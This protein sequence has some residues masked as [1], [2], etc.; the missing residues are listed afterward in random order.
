MISAVD[1]EHYSREA[2]TQ[3]QRHQSCKL[4]L[5]EVE[6]CTSSGES[7]LLARHAAAFNTGRPCISVNEARCVCTPWHMLG[8]IW[9]RQFPAH[10]QVSGT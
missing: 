8:T 3:H 7:A 10:A 6:L 9:T 4:L 2:D 1:A 5:I